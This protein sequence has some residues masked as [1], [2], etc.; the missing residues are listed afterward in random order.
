MA[1][2]TDPLD[3]KTALL[4]KLSDPGAG[5]MA[6]AG[7]AGIAPGEMSPNAGPP[8]AVTPPL[9]AVPPIADI[10]K[11]A[12]NYD[13]LNAGFDR[14]KLNDPNKHSAKYDMARTFAQF[15]PKAGITSDV[16]DALNKL[17]YGTF[18]GSGDKLSLSGLTDAGRKAGLTGDYQGADDV[19]GLHSDHPQWSYADP[20][21][22]AQQGGGAAAGPGGGPMVG[23]MAPMGNPGIDQLLSG[24]PMAKIQ[25]A[26]AQLSGPNS[27]RSNAEALLQ[28]LMGAKNG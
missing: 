4:K 14:N 11:P 19:Q 13:N 5:P 22:E 26:L 2:L 6:T 8:P 16:T 24:D 21:A 10:P 17:G 9:G 7:A 28:S 18:S 23:G 3:P 15:D 25:A 27:Q 20:Y 1:D 12:A